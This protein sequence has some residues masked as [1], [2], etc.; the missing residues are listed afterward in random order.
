MEKKIVLHGY[1]K[2]SCDKKLGQK[3]LTQ[4]LHFQ[5]NSSL[6]PLNLAFLV[7]NKGKYPRGEF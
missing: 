1:W 4:R 5:S 7:Q 6:Q 2:L 3:A